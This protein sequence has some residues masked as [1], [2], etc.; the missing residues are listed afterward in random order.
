M[1]VGCGVVACVLIERGVQQHANAAYLVL[2]VLAA[3]GCAASA[4]AA[5]NPP[6]RFSMNERGLVLARGRRFVP[7]GDVEEIRV[8]H[9]QTEYEEEHNLVLK[10][11]PAAEPLPHKFITTNATNP[12]EVELRLNHV[13]ASWNQVVSDV[14]AL[15]GIKVQAVRDGAFRLRSRPTVRD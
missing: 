5:I 3:A 8:A 13:S 11:K 1:A 10:L 7:W 2:G 15:S 4:R 9:H 14:Q 6:V 12:D